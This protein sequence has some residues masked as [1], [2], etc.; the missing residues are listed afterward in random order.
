[1]YK[2][3][4][5]VSYKREPGDNQLITP[6]LDKVLARVEYWVRQ[7]LG[8]RQVG[9]FIDTKSIEAGDDWP[10]TIRQA[11]LT[12]RCL[13]AIWSPEYFHSTWCVAEWRSFLSR[14][15]LLSERGQPACKLIVPITFHDGNWFPDEAKRIQQF[16]LSRFAATTEG[17]WGTSRADELDQ[18]LMTD[19]A[20]TLAKAVSQAPPFEVSWPVDLGDPTLPPS[21]VEMIRL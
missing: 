2:Y 5:F 1:M 4:L 3:D 12:A 18:I 15:K 16:D 21:D 9:V 10:D 20:P 11:L 14:E 19:V 17:F 13:L 7:E 8:G 6:W